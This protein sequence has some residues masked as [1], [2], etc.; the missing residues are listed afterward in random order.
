MDSRASHLHCLRHDFFLQQT[1]CTTCACLS[2]CT[3]DQLHRSPCILTPSG[4][5]PAP[6]HYFVLPQVSAVA[7]DNPIPGFGTN[8]CINL[9]LWAAKPSREFDLEAFNTGDYVQAIL[10]KQRAETLSSVLYPDDRH[11]EGKELRLKQQNFF[12]SATMQVGLGEWDTAR[13]AR[14]QQALLGQ[15]EA[16]RGHQWRDWELAHEQL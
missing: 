12:V 10:A 2:S 14:R 13:R 8:N 15:V 16:G 6:P 3:P 11:T 1:T 7:Y 9:R 4:P 5:P